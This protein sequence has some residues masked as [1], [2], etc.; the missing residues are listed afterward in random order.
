MGSNK[1]GRSK[2]QCCPVRNLYVKK[3]RKYKIGIKSGSS[4]DYSPRAPLESDFL[5]Y[6][7][8]S[9][10]GNGAEYFVACVVVLVKEGLFANRPSSIAVWPASVISQY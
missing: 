9:A 6:Q 5:Y 2:I 4:H 8:T 10:L 1:W 3:Y 7:I